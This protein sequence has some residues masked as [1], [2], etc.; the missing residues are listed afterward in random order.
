MEQLN[1]ECSESKCH[2]KSLLNSCI[3]S[4]K[5]LWLQDAGLSFS[6]GANL[7]LQLATYRSGITLGQAGSQGRNS[8]TT[9]AVPE[10]M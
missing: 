4:F 3:S 1:K 9:A 10:T 8:R 2:K 7:I 5:Q 6:T